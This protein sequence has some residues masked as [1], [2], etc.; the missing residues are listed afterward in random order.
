MF[1]ILQ[2]PYWT[3]LVSLLTILTAILFLFW[4]L[5]DLSCFTGVPKWQIISWVLF[6]NFHAFS[7]LRRI[8]QLFYLRKNVW[9]IKWFSAYFWL[10]K[11]SIFSTMPREQ[12]QYWSLQLSVYKKIVILNVI[13]K[14]KRRIGCLGKCSH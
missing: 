3:L 5:Q 13:E 2:L 4:Y 14:V 9:F 12:L 11:M 10:L 8:S 7:N 1:K 6:C